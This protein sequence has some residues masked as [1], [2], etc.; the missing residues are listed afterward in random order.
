MIPRDLGETG[1]EK[2]KQS[3]VVMTSRE[4]DAWATYLNRFWKMVRIWVGVGRGEEGWRLGV[5]GIHL[6]SVDGE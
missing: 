5:E 6:L 4:D 3:V 1:G 2:E